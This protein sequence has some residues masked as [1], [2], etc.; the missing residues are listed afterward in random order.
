MAAEK[1]N[2]SLKI[3][4]LVPTAVIPTR[5]TE[6]SVG[7]DLYS[8]KR[9]V[10]ASNNIVAIE[11]GISLEIPKGYFGL[12]AER[13]GFSLANGLSLKAG[14][15]DEDYRG[16]VKIIMQNSSDYPVTISSGSKIAQLLLLPAVYADIDEVDKLT[17][18]DRGAAGFGSTGN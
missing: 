13:S 3:K 14:V 15:I 11:T 7:L 16:E 12:I 5:G 10:I 8:I 17:D 9:Y 6:K 2:I 4:K 1:R 18:T